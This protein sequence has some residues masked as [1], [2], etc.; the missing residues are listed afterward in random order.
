MDAAQK[1]LRTSALVLA[2]SL[3]MAAPGWAQTLVVNTAVVIGSTGSSDQAV[4]S[5]AGD[6]TPITYTIGAPAYSGGRTGWL[7]VSG[8]TTTPASLHFA[9]AGSSAGLDGGFSHCPPDSDLAQPASRPVTITV[10]FN[11]GSSG[12][13]GGTSNALTASPNPVTF[14][15]SG[16]ASSGTITITNISA[17]TL[18]LSASATSSPG[19][20]LYFHRSTTVRSLPAAPRRSLFMPTRL[21]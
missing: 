7:N 14:S 2:V 21:A 6:A 17:N 4:T 9:L 19:A 15:G 20:W 5:S 3:L 10:T 1:L 16:T 8:G 13:G 12:G 11:G 18:T